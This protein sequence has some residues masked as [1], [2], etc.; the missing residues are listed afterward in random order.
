MP[1]KMMTRSMAVPFLVLALNLFVASAA[2]AQ[3]AITVGTVNA[4]GATVDVPIYIR[5]AAGTPLGMDRPVPARIQAI[6]IRVTYSPASA[7]SSVSF[8]RAGI[9]GGL[10]PA[11][12]TKP[13][14]AGA[15]SLL[16]S[17]QQSTNPIPFTLNASPPG[18]LVAHL[19]FT[20]SASATYGSDIA[21]TLDA[22]TT[23]L[24]DDGG[25]AATKETSANGQLELVS[26]AIHIA[27]PSLVLS[28]ATQ[29]ITTAETGTLSVRASSTLISNATVTVTSSDPSVA[30]VIVSTIIAAGSQ[31]A[32][33]I[34]NAHAPGS[35]TITATLPASA[36]G[37]TATASVTVT[38]AIDVCSPPAAPQI[39]GPSTALAGTTYSITW[40]NV[41]N[42]SEYVVDEATDAA[43]TTATSKTVTTNNA[44]FSH[45]AA[46]SRYYYRVRA[47]NHSG[48]CDVISIPSATISTLITAL[49][50]P[51]MRVLAV[52]GS[53]AGLFGSYFKTALQLYNPKAVT[54]SGRLVFHVQSI[55]GGAADPSFPYSIGAGKTLTFDDVLPAMGIAT[56]LGSVDL[57]ADNGS[58]FPIAVA[59]VFS[60]SGA[61]GTT[62]FTL[63][64]LATATALQPGETGAL[65]VPVD[66]GRFRLNVGVRTLDRVVAMTVTVRNRDG[67]VVK[68]LEKTI[69]ATY[70][71]QYNSAE[72]LDGFVLAGGETISVQMTSG[73]AFVY[74]A[75]TDNI[76]N[77]PSI[78][79]AIRIE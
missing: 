36:G 31:V 55:G 35:T 61:A 5:D 29:S 34:V 44:A 70:F 28:P 18:D 68:T 32:N 19:V 9:T 37:A 23:Q 2:F 25:S 66:M 76:T 60:D 24:T 69:A 41:A 52:V 38:Q 78:Q 79:F 50:P 17:F 57:I 59:R 73:A 64:A 26:G 47:R 54:V 72:F 22:A 4:T 12:E 6:S 42:A 14:S 56:G 49:P 11:F 30:T 40:T 27:A 43:F 75:T 10:S 67:I 48:T 63:D 8:D 15:V 46:D 13:A 20:L 74:G 51:A 53:T 39:G 16:A 77:D 33:I 71:R 65:L 45:D 3:D 58:A 7:V 1:E 62:G 21:L